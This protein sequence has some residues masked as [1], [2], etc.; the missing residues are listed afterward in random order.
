MRKVPTV[1][2]TQAVTRAVSNELRSWFMGRLRG[3]ENWNLEFGIS[4]GA[5]M[6]WRGAAGG[7]SR[8]VNV[9]ALRQ[10]GIFLGTRR[11][12]VQ[13]PDEDLRQHSANEGHAAQ[14]QPQPLKAESIRATRRQDVEGNVE[15]VHQPGPEA[16]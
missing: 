4:L 10:A 6:R 2:M 13:V 14:V 15:E 9:Q 8:H 3:F 16:E 11:V 7:R 12:R 1:P 5:S